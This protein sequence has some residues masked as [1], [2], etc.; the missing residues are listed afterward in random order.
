MDMDIGGGAALSDFDEGSEPA[1]KKTAARGKKAA[2]PAKKA[3]AKKAPAKRG[4]KAA[5][6]VTH[7]HNIDDWLMYGVPF[8]VV[9][10]R[11]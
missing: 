8:I 9:R 3:P 5:V 1:P 7:F 4:K 6:S 11:G 2:A 10:R